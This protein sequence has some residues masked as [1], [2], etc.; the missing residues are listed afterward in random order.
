MFPD[1]Q[2]AQVM[3]D[4]RLGNQVSSHLDTLH[5][6]L[7]RWMGD[8]I[9]ALRNECQI[10]ELQAIDEP[11][12]FAFADLQDRLSAVDGRLTR[13]QRRMATKIEQYLEDNPGLEI[14][15]DSFYDLSDELTTLQGMMRGLLE[16]R[17]L[18]DEAISQLP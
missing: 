1:Y 10:L 12:K 16:I 3:R 13:N 7:T 18:V 2:A 6:V 15:L 14:P 4:K 11:A 8:E 9:H 5:E 17:E